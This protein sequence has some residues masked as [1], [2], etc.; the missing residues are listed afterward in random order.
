MTLMDKFKSPL[1]DQTA[2]LGGHIHV[3]V[4]MPPKIGEPSDWFSSGSSFVVIDSLD[5]DNYR[6]SWS[7]VIL[8]PFLLHTKRWQ[9]L[10]VDEITGKTKYY[11]IEAFG[12]LLAYLIWFLVGAKL[13]VGFHAAAESL[14]N[15]SEEK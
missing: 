3:K 6:V 10:T 4:N 14:K 15:R 2:T 13:R 7:S 5:H 1:P 12:G 11:T 9:G 8:T